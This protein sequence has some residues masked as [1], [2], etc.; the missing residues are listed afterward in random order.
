MGRVGMRLF[1]RGPGLVVLNAI[2]PG[3]RV[4]GSCSFRVGYRH[5][6]YI[7]GDEEYQYGALAAGPAYF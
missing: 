5:S 4:L 2:G 6:E 1:A 7:L 3:G